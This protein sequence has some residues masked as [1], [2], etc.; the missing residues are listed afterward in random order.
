MKTF[1][2][3]LFDNLFW[4]LSFEFGSELQFVKLVKGKNDQQ[5]DFTSLTNSNRPQV[6]MAWDYK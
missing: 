3:C 2:N 6:V 1:Q 4:Y 5:Y